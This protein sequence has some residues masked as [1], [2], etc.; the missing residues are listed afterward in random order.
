MGIDAESANREIGRDV[1]M[2]FSSAIENAGLARCGTHVE[3]ATRFYELW[4]LKDAYVK[5]T[6]KRLSHPLHT[7]VFEIRDDHSIARSDVDA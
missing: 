4:V 5:A 7:I 6:G 3:R 2:R 1:A